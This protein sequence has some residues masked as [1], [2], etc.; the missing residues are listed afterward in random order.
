MRFARLPGPQT[1]PDE[2]AMAFRTL[3]LAPHTHELSG[4]PRCGALI[5]LQNSLHYRGIQKSSR[6]WLNGKFVNLLVPAAY[7]IGALP[8]RRILV[9]EEF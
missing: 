4:V 9:D 5:L 7:L 6:S 8:P 3:L 1:N 2:V